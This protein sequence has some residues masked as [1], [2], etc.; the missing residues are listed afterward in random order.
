MWT[1]HSRYTVTALHHHHHHQRI[2]SS[3]T[4]TS[5]PLHCTALHSINQLKH[6]S[7]VYA[8]MTNV[9]LRK[10]LK[11]TSRTHK[12][13]TCCSPAT[14]G[15][16]ESASQQ[17]RPTRHVPVTASSS[18]SISSHHSASSYRNRN[19]V[20]SNAFSKSAHLLHTASHSYR[21]PSF[22]VK[23]RQHVFH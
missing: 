7:A 22:Q 3:L 23:L 13:L 18:S 20:Q 16:R 14:E 11:H 1:S 19:T 15:L 8:E 17:R 6:G 12:P 21:T 2:S 5:G 10:T 9:K 4:K